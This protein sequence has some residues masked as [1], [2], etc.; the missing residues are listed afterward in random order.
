MRTFI[1]LSLLIF[2]F[3]HYDTCAHASQA[4]TKSIVENYI[5]IVNQIGN[6]SQQSSTGFFNY[7]LTV[8]EHFN[9]DQRIKYL[10]ISKNA[11]QGFEFQIQVPHSMKLNHYFQLFTVLQLDIYFNTFQYF[12]QSSNQV[13]L[14]FDMQKFIYFARSMP[15]LPL[16]RILADFNDIEFHWMTPISAYETYVNSE[17]GSLNGQLYFLRHLK[18][19]LTIL[20]E[21]YPYDSVQNQSQYS[22]FVQY[23]QKA[24]YLDSPNPSLSLSQIIKALDSQITNLKT[25]TQKM[26]HKNLKSYEI[27][28]SRNQ[29]LLLKTDLSD[30]VK[31]NARSEVA[32]IIEMIIPWEVLEPTEVKFWRDYIE[33]IRQPKYDQS[34]VIFRGSDEKDRL[35]LVVNENNQITDIAVFAKKLTTGSGSYVY[36]LLGLP[37]LFERNGVLGNKDYYKPYEVPH[38]FTA[39]I[40]NHSINPL[41][42]TFISW[43]LSPDIAFRFV[44][45]SNSLVANSRQRIEKVESDYLLSSKSGAVLAARIDPRRLFINSFSG[46]RQEL[47]VV[48]PLIVFPDEI[49]HFKKGLRYAIYQNGE[50]KKMV[51][52]N[53][54]DFTQ[55]LAEKMNPNETLD[56]LKIANRN[57]IF[58]MGLSNLIQHF[59]LVS[60]DAQNEVCQ[61]VFQ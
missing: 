24:Y 21:H 49:V 7:Q 27:R 59:I 33:A 6:K 20:N 48:A 5:Q 4:K 32:E 12:D 55:H 50:I 40:T 16:P 36:R 26:Y 61:K 56:Q 34:F 29:S 47:E 44:T 53:Q 15:R 3:V 22:D 39:L 60:P 28:K 45:S 30:L 8:S 54:F 10:M 37:H 43:S 31:R 46:Y 42:S 51:N 23:I 19:T 41:G 52:E 38:S 9:N 2:Q 1:L 25:V 11:N 57:L 14:R 17:F 18:N 13:D 58:Q 35:Q